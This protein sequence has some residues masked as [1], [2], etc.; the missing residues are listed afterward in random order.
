MS[1]VMRSR[2]SH[3]LCQV[4]LMAATTSRLIALS[5]PV[6]IERRLA[7]LV[8]VWTSFGTDYSAQTPTHRPRLSLPVSVSLGTRASAVRARS[9]PT[10]TMAR[11]PTSK[12][13]S[14][15]LAPTDS[16][17]LHKRPPGQAWT[18]C[19]VASV[20]PAQRPRLHQMVTAPSTPR[21]P[22]SRRPHPPPARAL[23]LRA[24][25]CRRFSG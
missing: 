19:I 3:Q 4:R 20:G 2:S 24:L 23:T 21:P 22:P 6:D 1:R 9:L 12:C 8:P 11:V 16:S 13:P 25:K 5:V 18:L 7:R 15:A 14:S 10:L 17:A